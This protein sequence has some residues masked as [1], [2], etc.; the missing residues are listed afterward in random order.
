MA[1]PRFSSTAI[2]SPILGR[3][4]RFWTR[5][6]WPGSSIRPSAPRPGKGET[7]VGIQDYLDRAG[8]P[9][10][11]KLSAALAVFSHAAVL[12]GGSLG[13]DTQPE[14]GMSGGVAS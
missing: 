5:R 13:I 3:W 8:T 7:S 6:G 11:W 4:S 10:R 9:T 1:K 12:L 14:D 2:R